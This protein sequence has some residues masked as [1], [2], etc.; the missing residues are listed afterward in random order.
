[1]ANHPLTILVFC[2]DS[3]GRFNASFGLTRKLKKRC[4]RVVYLVPERYQ[5]KLISNGF[6]VI[7]GKSGNAQA[8]EENLGETLAKS[9]LESG[10]IGPSSPRKKLEL[11]LEHFVSSPKALQWMIGLSEDFADAMEQCQ[12][13]V[14][15]I[16]HLFLPP[17]L[18][19]FGTPW[20]KFISTNPLMEVIDE[21]LPPGCSG[22]EHSPSAMLQSIP[23]FSQGFPQMA[24]TRM[25]G[26]TLPKFVTN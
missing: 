1:M 17:A 3:I 22:K 25:N 4:H 23:F 8:D 13:D 15:I 11:C 5:E 21:K 18:Y 9:L 12:P 24:S 14:V 2:I 16:D 26:P 10:I 7:L 20:V 19:H 6:E